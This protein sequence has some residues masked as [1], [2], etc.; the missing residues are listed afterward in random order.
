MSVWAKATN[1]EYRERVWE[2]RGGDA[3]F[4]LAFYERLCTV[5]QEW[6]INGISPP[7]TYRLPADEY[8]LD[9]FSDQT[10]DESNDPSITSSNLIGPA[11]RSGSTSVRSA[12]V[13]SASSTPD[14]IAAWTERTDGLSHDQYVR[15]SLDA[16]RKE[17]REERRR[18]EATAVRLETANAR[19]ETLTR[20]NA[21]ISRELASIR[22]LLEQSLGIGPSSAERAFD[23]EEVE[24]LPG[25]SG[26]SRRRASPQKKKKG[27][28]KKLAVIQLDDS[29]V[30]VEDRDDDRRKSPS[31]RGGESRGRRRR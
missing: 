19:L 27:S 18:S 24:P 17:A 9:Q 3:T 1:R 20:E 10:Y 30:E 8:G 23:D 11:S 21:T 12:S 2:E 16:L 4:A 31:K 15:A 28:G 14:T 7:P 29:D 26:A 5:Y 25:P 22:L 13:R 6:K